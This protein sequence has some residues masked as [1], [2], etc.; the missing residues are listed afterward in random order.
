M[1]SMFLGRNPPLAGKS[2][3][4]KWVLSTLGPAP[5]LQ[6]GKTFLWPCSLQEPVETPETQ[7]A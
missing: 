5:P 4:R 7:I 3:W 2:F 1:E 6:G